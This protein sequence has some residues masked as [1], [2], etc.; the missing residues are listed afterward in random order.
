MNFLKVLTLGTMILLM[1]LSASA[2]DLIPKPLKYQQKNE[3]FSLNQNTKIVYAEPL[4]ELASY[5]FESLSA[6]TGWDL[7]M[8]PGSK[9]RKNSILLKIDSALSDNKEAY[10]LS[11]SSDLVIISGQSSAGVFNGIQTLMQLMPVHVYSKIR[12]RNVDWVVQGAEIED[13]PLYP[14]RGMMLDVSR[15]F[16]DKDYVLHLIDMMAMYKMNVLHLHLI[17]DA[18]W[19]LEI[20]K[21]PKLTSI[22]GFRGEGHE[23]TGGYYTQEDIKEIV[24]YAA[25]RNVEVIPEIEIPAHTLAAIAA[26]PYLSCTEKELKVPLQHFISRDLYCVGKES[27]FE[28]LNNVF[29][30]T[31]ELFPSNYIHI[32]GDEA[33]YDR[34]K[35][36]PHCQQRKK[37][38]GLTNEAEL[39]VYFTKRVQEM[40]KTYGKTIV[41]WDEILEKGLDDKAVGMIWHNKKKA[42]TG[43]RDGHDVVMALT[44]HCYFDVAESKIPGEVKAATW[45]PPISLEAVYALNPM[46]EGLEEQYRSQVLGGHATLWSDQFIHGTVLQEIVPIN[47]NRSEKYFDY[48]TFPRMAALSEAVWTPV[49]NKEWGDFQRRM[50]FHYP[51][52]DQAGYGYRVPQPKLIS[53]DKKGEQFEVVLDNVV[54][55]AQIRYTTD[56][57]RPNPYSPVYESPVLID[58]LSD[59]Q[60][61]T[62]VNR[63]QYSLPLHF[64]EKYEPFKQ[65]GQYIGEWKPSLIKG[66]EFSILEL[67]A[68]GKIDKNGNYELA[69]LYTK[70]AYK[71]EI[72]S[73]EVFKNGHKIGEDVHDGYTGGASNDNI[74]RFAIEEYETG[75]A[76][77]I[78]AKVRGDW[79]N[80]SNGVV[81]IKRK[82]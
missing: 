5:L 26:Y 3:V 73:V 33:N 76:F 41:G 17:D 22:G 10:T 65:Y 7:A 62:V 49:E 4:A 68:S 2:A 70:G 9:G 15:Y 71:L 18:G 66:E 39:Q 61:V 8:L 44:G 64:P 34:W 40:V 43:T 48:L 60:A 35:E 20:K 32:G 58:R 75:A 27:T 12:Q 81:F 72:Q 23:R 38:I 46:I 1:N 13:A 51:R 56:G 69:F 30:E 59:F 74:Y 52:L 53:K 16:Y 57:V 14:W 79:G 11:V 19:R 55:G 45:L 25:L 31:F 47:E 78:K 54:E 67:N 77:T 37:D 63:Q 21:Y 36:C 80:D 28:F 24:A 6:P 29:K 82:E 42:I 50:A